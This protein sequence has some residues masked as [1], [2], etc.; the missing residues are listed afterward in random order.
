MLVKDREKDIIER[1][2]GEYPQAGIVLNYSNSFELL[3]AVIL[4]AQC[5]DKKVNEVTVG[6]FKKYK[7]INDYA[8]VSLEELEQDIRPTGFFRN[9]ARNIKGAASMVIDRFG[10]EVP[11]TMEELIQLPGVARKTAN[12]V[13]GNAFG[14]VEGIAVDTHVKRL[15]NR[16]GLSENANPVRVERDLMDIIPKDEWFTFT[17]LLIEHGRAICGARKPRCDICVLN[18]RCP[19]TFTF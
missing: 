19:S 14:V 9:K 2:R 1:L 17:Y 7:N 13:L 11:S 4:S 5:T 16:L 18:D 6:L 15:S 12:I 3:V 8:D 10:G